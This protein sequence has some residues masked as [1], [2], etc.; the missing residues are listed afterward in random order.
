M[1]EG[2]GTGTPKNLMGVG[3]GKDVIA[4]G[5]GGEGA[6]LKARWDGQF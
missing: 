3:E 6:T 5:I 2:I 1:Q 4:H